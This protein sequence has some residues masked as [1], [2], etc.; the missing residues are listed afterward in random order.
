MKLPNELSYAEKCRLL[1]IIRSV[2]PTRWEEIAK[3]YGWVGGLGGGIEGDKFQKYIM[4]GLQTLNAEEYI[5]V[6][7]LD[8]CRFEQLSIRIKGYL[9]IFAYKMNLPFK[10]IYWVFT[11]GIVSAAAIK[12]LFGE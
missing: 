5:N 6:K 1:E 12:T 2:K 10:I 4:L 7:I 8:I 3:Q 9:L 11:V